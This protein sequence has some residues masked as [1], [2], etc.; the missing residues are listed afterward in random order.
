MQAFKP[1]NPIWLMRT[2]VR[3][4]P[5]ELPEA[6][7]AQGQLPVTLLEE[8]EPIEV[9]NVLAVHNLMK[10]VAG[11][12]VQVRETVKEGDG[13]KLKLTLFRNGLSIQDWRQQ[14]ESQGVSLYDEKGRPLTRGGLNAE[15]NGDQ[16]DYDMTFMKADEAGNRTGSAPAAKPASTPSR[17][18]VQVPLEP[19]QLTVPF[20]FRDLSIEK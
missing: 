10:R 11:R 17:L 20:E 19:K 3:Q 15:D 18:V 12:T 13:Y 7:P 2:D 8:S 6:G 14:R 1:E 4:V 9:N 5:A 16:V